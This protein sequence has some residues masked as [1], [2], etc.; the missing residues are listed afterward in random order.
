MHDLVIENA[1]IVDGL[2]NPPREGALAVKDGRIA[3]LGADL[4][5]GHERLDAEGLMLAPGIVDLYT[6]FDA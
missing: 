3:A 4:G 1:R 6:H 2:G 5:P